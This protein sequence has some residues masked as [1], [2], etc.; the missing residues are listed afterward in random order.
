MELFE[1]ISQGL[2]NEDYLV[3]LFGVLTGFAL[4]GAVVAKFTKTP[5]DD[6]FFARLGEAL[7]RVVVSPK[8]PKDPK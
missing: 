5:R 4:V 1:L 6:A 2:T 3:V 7:K 8:K